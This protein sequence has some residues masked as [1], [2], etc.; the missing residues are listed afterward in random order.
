M[1]TD[2][3]SLVWCGPDPIP[4]SLGNQFG[5]VIQLST[6]PHNKNVKLKLEN[7]CS[8]LAQDLE[9]IA[10]DLL[11]VASYVYCADQAVTRGGRTWPQNGRGWVRRFKF[12]IPVRCVE[13]WRNERVT[14]CLRETLGFLSD[15]HYNFEFRSLHKDIPRDAYFDFDEGQPWFKADSVLLFSGGLD[16]LTGAVSELS[17][18][19]RNVALVS[20]RPAP[21]IDSR[22]K[23]LVAQ[24]VSSAQDKA[25]ILHVPIWVNKHLGI[26]KDANQRS[27]S[28]LYLA[29]GAAVAR[30]LH[31]DEIKFYENG[32]VSIN[33]PISEQVIGGRASRSTHPKVLNG[34]Q[35]LLSMIYE[36]KF[37][38]ENP[39]LWKTKSDVVSS[40]LELDGQQLISSTCSCSHTRQFTKTHTHCGVCSQCIERRIATVFNG[41]EDYDPAYSYRTDLFT[42][43]LAEKLDRSMVISYIE[44]A[45]I[46]EQAKDG[47]FFERF[48]EAL[49]VLDCLGVATSKAAQAL[50][51]L[52]KRHGKQVGEVLESQIKKHAHEIRTGM[53]EGSSLLAAHIG[54]RAVAKDAP[55][56]GSRFPTPEGADWGDVV[57]EIVSDIAAKITVSST[58]KS[59]TAFEMG[60]KDKRTPDEPTK[61]WKLL[62]LLAQN[63]GE[64]KW[65]SKRTATGAQKRVQELRRSLRR[66][67]GIPGPPISNYS[68]KTGYQTLFRIID[69]RGQM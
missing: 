31:I 63:Q 68:K 30:M 2:E 27:R 51:D 5:R 14:E 8:R 22:Q 28:F 67:F 7:I 23:Q 29:L 59:Y 57:I 47:E 19:D 35:R 48:P 65:T 61:Q 3:A 39:F 18:S 26:T 36:R 69:Q 10:V 32:I 11:E 56:N 43:S 17:H 41:V 66:F 42:G 37:R 34:F 38:I 52:H 21:Q 1:A 54:K 44:H 13:I 20:H 53:L 49:R 58:T 16:S 15:D 62:V 40:L 46:L 24:L 4:R 50:F 33:L 9:P 64:L 45:R 6:F 12:N 55:T 60:L 25:S